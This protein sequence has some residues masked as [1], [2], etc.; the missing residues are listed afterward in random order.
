MGRRM[1]FL[2]FVT[3]PEGSGHLGDLGPDNRIINFL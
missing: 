1:K 3:K 2:L